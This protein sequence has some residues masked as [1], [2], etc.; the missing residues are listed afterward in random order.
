MAV[1]SK[2]SIVLDRGFISAIAIG[3][4][5][6]PDLAWDVLFNYANKK[7]DDYQGILVVSSIE[8]V[9]KRSKTHMPTSQ[10]RQVLNSDYCG[11]QRWMADITRNKHIIVQNDYETVSELESFL[12][13]QITRLFK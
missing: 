1:D 3:K 8:M 11:T 13:T 5:Y 7:K 6:C 2:D 12:D 4:I 10:D 9:I